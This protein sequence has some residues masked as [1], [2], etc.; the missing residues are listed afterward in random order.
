MSL[1]LT[2][3][4]DTYKALRAKACVILGIPGEEIAVTGADSYIMPELQARDP[5]TLDP[6]ISTEPEPTPD[7]APVKPKRAPVKPKADPVPVAAVPVEEQGNPAPAIVYDDV[8]KLVLDLSKDP[9][10]RP[11]VRAI[12][13]TFDVDHATKLSPEQWP[14]AHAALAKLAGVEVDTDEAL[15]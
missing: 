9:K 15:G 11:D 3:T 8:R 10:T 4:A 7:A 5:G 1:T 14:A 6:A 13:A 2:I 12:L